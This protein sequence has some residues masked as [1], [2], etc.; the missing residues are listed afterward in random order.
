MV[1]CW[2]VALHR[3]CNLGFPP[4]R[5]Q[6]VGVWAIPSSIRPPLSHLPFCLPPCSSP[7]HSHTSYAIC[8]PQ[9]LP[10]VVAPI[11]AGEPQS[12]RGA[13]LSARIFTI[14]RWTANNLAISHHKFYE[15]GRRA[16]DA[17]VTFARY[18]ATL[19]GAGTRTRAWRTTMFMGG[20]GAGDALVTMD[21]G[22]HEI[23]WRKKAGC[24]G[25]FSATAG[26]TTTTHLPTVHMLC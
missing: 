26:R 14:F 4:I 17:T 3:T 23:S 5:E 7:S 25:S 1:R 9:S 19:T 13:A 24:T 16:D 20:L 10:P 18:N 22:L 11:A 2:V 6:A 12:L 15:R 8:M 21:G